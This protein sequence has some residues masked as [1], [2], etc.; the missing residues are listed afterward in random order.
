MPPTVVGDCAVAL[1]ATAARYA[2]DELRADRLIIVAAAGEMPEQLYASLGF[3]AAGLQRGVQR[4]G[5]CGRQ[6]P[7]G[8]VRNRRSR[9]TPCNSSASEAAKHQRR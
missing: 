5:D 6:P 1:I 2:R 3:V 7:L 8:C 4:N 9:S